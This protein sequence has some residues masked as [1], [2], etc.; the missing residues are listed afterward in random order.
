[1]VRNRTEEIIMVVPIT[2]IL[3]GIENL[4]I[5]LVLVKRIIRIIILITSSRS[6]KMIY[7]HSIMEVHAVMILRKIMME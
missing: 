6:R 7:Q 2:V 3:L 1:M 4:V 5:L